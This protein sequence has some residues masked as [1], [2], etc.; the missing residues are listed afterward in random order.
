MKVTWLVRRYTEPWHHEG[1]ILIVE[2]ITVDFVRIV[3]WIG[4]ENGTSGVPE[5]LHLYVDLLR[6]GFANK[7]V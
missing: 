2:R 1:A 5:Y 6:V 4:T 3:C 7:C